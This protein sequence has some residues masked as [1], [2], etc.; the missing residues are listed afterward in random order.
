MA[1]F[2]RR[3]IN[4]GVFTNAI[5]LRGDDRRVLE[6]VNVING[7]LLDVFKRTMTA[8]ARAKVIVIDA[9]TQIRPCAFCGELYVRS[10]CFNVDVRFVGVA[11]A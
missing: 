11:S 7:R 1:N 10:F 8:M 9:G 2:P 3:L 6:C 4:S 5:A